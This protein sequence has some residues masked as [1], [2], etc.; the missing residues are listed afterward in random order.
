MLIVPVEM[1]TVTPVWTGNIRGESVQLMPQSLIGSLRFWFKVYCKATGVICDF[2]EHEEFPLKAYLDHLNKIIKSKG[3][4]SLKFEELVLE[5][6]RKIDDRGVGKNKL[7]VVAK[8]F[9]C[10]GWR[11]MIHIQKIT[12]IDQKSAYEI[13]DSLFKIR[14]RNLNKKTKIHGRYNIT[15][16][17]AHPCLKETILWPLL[18]FVQKYG[19]IGAL[20][21]DGLGR[22]EFYE[23]GEGN[24]R[25]KTENF[26]FSPISLHL[27]QVK[28]NIGNAVHHELS[29]KNELVGSHSKLMIW[30][31]HEK[32]DSLSNLIDQ[33]WT[34]CKEILDSI[35]MENR[36]LISGSRYEGAKI[37]PLISRTDDGKYYTGAWLSLMMLRS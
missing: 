19:F 28:M 34:E 9:G 36:G 20:N 35:G 13:V 6:I 37:L 33:M 14:N 24:G 16:C 29:S 2:R 17:L 10:T 21:G 32:F 18:N 7:S 15:F 11:S 25:I 26:D 1:E 30:S 5:S 27:S 22:V 4:V 3:T 8:L 23:I 12:P 31:S